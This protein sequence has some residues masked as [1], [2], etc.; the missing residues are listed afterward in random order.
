MS[1]EEGS[2]STKSYSWDDL[3]QISGKTSSRPQTVYFACMA[4]G[5]IA[6]V[7]SILTAS[8]TCCCL[9]QRSA[10]RHLE[11]SWGNCPKWSIFV[12][13]LLALIVTIVSWATIFAMPAA[14]DDLDF[15]Q[16]EGT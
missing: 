15:L 14:L 1:P 11:D 13:S 3:D 10:R 4:L 16:C 12:V 7:M 5:G 8:F 2:D 6:I 9:M